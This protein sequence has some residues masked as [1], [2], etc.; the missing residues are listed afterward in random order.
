MET[1]IV[2]SC[3]KMP[4]KALKSLDNNKLHG[5]TIMFF[6]NFLSPMLEN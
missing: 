1:L 6:I 3:Q 4:L 5:L 2:C